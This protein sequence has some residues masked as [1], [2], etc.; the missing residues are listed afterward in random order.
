MLCEVIVKI[1]RLYNICYLRQ[2]MIM[3][4]LSRGNFHS[5]LAWLNALIV[6]L[7]LKEWNSSV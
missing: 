7:L 6:L 1:N 2:I 4:I 3:I 5:F